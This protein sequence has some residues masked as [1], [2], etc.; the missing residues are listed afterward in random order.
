MDNEPDIGLVDSHAKGIGRHHHTAL[1]GGPLVLLVLLVLDIKP[2]MIEVGM[3]TSPIEL[4]TNLLCAFPG[5]HIH[6]GRTGHRAKDVNEFCDF[7]LGFAYY[8]RQVVACKA[9]GIHI[10]GF[11]SQAMLDILNHDRSGCSRQCK[12]RSIREKFAHLSDAQKRRPEI[13]A[14]LRDTM[15]LVHDN[16]RNR[17]LAQMLQE[18]AGLQ[19]L[20]RDIKEL[21]IAVQA[22]LIDAVHLA[23]REACIQ[24]IRLDVQGAQTIH[25]VFHQ[26]DDGR[27]D[28]RHA[29]HDHRGN[30]K[31]D[32]FASACGHQAQGV[33]PLEHRID[34]ILLERPERI[35]SPILLEDIK[36]CLGT[37]R[38][39]RAVLWP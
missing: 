9:H 22:L 34:D 27:D 26:R 39:P 5:T 18:R 10:G 24:V 21:T 12:N 14:P 29:I 3:N 2:R 38:H 11:E 28:K 15:C 37:G 32:G 4:V 36:N 33:T 20:G 35:I 23:T 8:I 6:D 30:L 16:Q 19:P 7:F 1:V 17:H 31:S 13:I 25:L